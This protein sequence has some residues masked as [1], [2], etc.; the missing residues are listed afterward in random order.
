M[1]GQDARAFRDFTIGFQ[2]GVCGGERPP[3]VP[4]ARSAKL[5][6]VGI[7]AEEGDCFWNPRRAFPA[8]GCGCVFSASSLSDFAKARSGCEKQ[9]E[10]ARFANIDRDTPMLMPPDMRDWV[11]DDH[12]VKFILDAVSLLDLSTAHVNQRGT[13][14]AQYPPATML[15]L[16]IYSYATGTFRSRQPRDE[17]ASTAKRV[18][19]R[20]GERLG[21]ARSKSSAARTK[22]CPCAT[23]AQAPIPATTPS[24]P[25]G[26][27][28]ANCSPKTRVSS[29]LRAGL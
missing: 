19:P 10:A 9:R 26:C 24:A 29:I 4:R 17:V 21:A 7:R 2:K 20:S 25:S 11:S 23:S 6:A 12:L 3:G 15:A 27:K 1:Q 18:L 16:L 8:T 13:G 14:D 22:A 28:T 5:S